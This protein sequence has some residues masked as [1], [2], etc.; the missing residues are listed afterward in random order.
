[1]ADEDKESDRDILLRIARELK[2]IREGIG[3]VLFAVGES[4]AEVP[5][6]F[7]HFTAYVHHLQSIMWLYTERGHQVPPYILKEVERCD[8]R[9]RQLL[10]E[11]H[12]DGGAFEKVRASM[13]NDP[14]NRWDHT[15]LLPG[16]ASE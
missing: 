12:T 5:M 6:K 1:M 4:E 10:T 11:L 7:L 15:R 8:D 3:K 16:K 13:A 9:L 14:E 2:T